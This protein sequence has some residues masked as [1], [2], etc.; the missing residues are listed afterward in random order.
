MFAGADGGLTEGQRA[1]A[2]AVREFAATELR[3][4]A[5]TRDAEERFPEAAWDGLAGMGT[6]GLAVPERYGGEGADRTTHAVV[7]EAVAHGSLA[8]AT[9]LSVHWLATACIGSFGSAAQRERWLPEMADG[10]PVGM[11]ALSEPGA[12]SNPAEMETVAR[13]EGDEYVIEGE[14]AWI[15]NGARGEVCILFAKTD[16]DDPDSITQFLVP[17]STGGVTVGPPEHKL[18]LRASDTTGLRFDGARIPAANRLT[19]EGRGLS[20]ALS[21]LTGGRI[22]IA[23]AATGLAQ[24]ALDEAIDH[25]GERERS[26]DPLA[27]VGAVRQRI[28]GMATRVHAARTAVREA[29]RQDDAGGDPRLAAS[30]AKLFAGE[31]AVEVCGEAVQVHGGRG[32]VRGDVERFYRDAK[33]TTIYEGTSEIQREI[34]ARAL[35]D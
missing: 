6:T 4:G 13:R 33:V 9:A 26:G 31:A 23:A 8:V 34:I 14:K 22:A 30:M 11:F 20:A 35:L 17:K 3:P 32:Y 25:V 10:R 12:G 24:A 18:G 7:A 21:V 19:P 29:A 5:A 16:P 28:A 2:E 15:T 27:A 1:V